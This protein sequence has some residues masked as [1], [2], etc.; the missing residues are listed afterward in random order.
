M[1]KKKENS[2]KRKMKGNHTYYRKIRKDFPMS[3]KLKNNWDIET[4]YCS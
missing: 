4:M 3:S 1:G 2:F